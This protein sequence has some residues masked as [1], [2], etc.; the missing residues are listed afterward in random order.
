MLADMSRKC[1]CRGKK[2]LLPCWPS[3]AV[4]E[5]K[6]DIHPSF[7]TQGRRHENSKTG[8]SEAPQKGHVSLQNLKNK[9]SM[10][11]RNPSWL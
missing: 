5:R 2:A 8:V 7:E 1:K 11:V 6:R 9:I 10:Q 3:L 4:Q